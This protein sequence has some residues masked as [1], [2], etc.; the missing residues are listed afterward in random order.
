MSTKL[1]W[2]A[3]ATR[4][5][6]SRLTHHERITASILPADAPNG[7]GRY[8]YAFGPARLDDGRVC[9]RLWAPDAARHGQA[10]RLEI[11]GMGPV[12][13]T[14]AQDGW[15]LAAVPCCDGARYWFRLDD[16]TTVPDPAS[17]FQPDDVHGPSVACLPSATGAYAWKC[18]DWCGRPWHE[19]I[20]YELHVGLCGGY[21]S[22]TLQL[23]RLADMG[24]TAVEL[25]PLAEFP[26]ARNWGY[27]GVLPF[28][29]ESAYG[30]PDQL[31][32]LVDHAH[33]L[34]LMVLLD[35]VYNHFGPEG[36]YLSLYAS[37][38]FRTDRK[39]PWG[40][41]IDYRR[42]EVRRFFFENA[43]YWLEEFRLDG[44][45]L[46]AVHAM[47]DDGWLAAL[48]G[49]LRDSLEAAGGAGRQIHLILENDNN[50]AGLLAAGYDAQWNDDAHHAL[51]VL[52][53]GETEGY[54]VDYSGQGNQ[55]PVHHLA[56]VLAEGFAYQ[57]EVSSYRSR[58]GDGT[59][60][61]VR[62]GQAS[63]HLPP[64]AF[65][66][67]LQNHDQ[68][69]NR[70]FGERLAGLIDPRALRAAVSLLLLCP[71]VP[72]VFIGEENGTDTP[73]LYFTSH[74]PTMAEAVRDGRRREFAAAHAFRDETCAASIPDPNDPATF[75]ASR[76]PLDIENDWTHY[77]RCL[78]AIRQRHLLARLPGSRSE[79]VD[80][81]GPAA[82][83]ARWQLG[84]GAR[85]L[86][87]LNLGEAAV[88]CS[89]PPGAAL[90]LHESETGHAA[91][92]AA[93][94]LP[95]MSCVAMMCVPD[96]L[97]GNGP[98]ASAN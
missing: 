52:L 95:P 39:T 40:P 82:L 89:A 87:W 84:D 21:A 59:H 91:A 66:T 16:G 35:V 53:T 56:R 94:S 26:G 85:L 54:Y 73:F 83:C 70:A 11:A 42:P 8:R 78:L 45:R 34:G 72:L 5:H 60:A 6:G 27:D 15:Y 10:V 38:F 9:F 20:V 51:H 46:D 61:A 50:N 13:M 48:P 14:L 98:D 71:Q 25:M 43:Y 64:T 12:P 62:R 33:D 19:A 96:G 41:V 69:G 55:S 77:Y 29:P 30:T 79:G 28:A 22:A 80:V 7:D 49:E 36:N 1:S 17:R 3:S 74:S 92:L 75:E 58:A 44:L 24:F 97:Q 57:G 63:A 68:T 65:V 67:F 32:A 81:L 90:L 93:H 23:K 31:R 88:P 2:P 86:L 47:D 4:P 18:P 76:P 37:D